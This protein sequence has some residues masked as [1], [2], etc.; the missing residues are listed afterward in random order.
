MNGMAGM[1]FADI[2]VA[3]GIF[4][5]SVTLLAVCWA[6]VR[7]RQLGAA[8]GGLAAVGAI[9]LIASILTTAEDPGVDQL[10]AQLAQL[11]DKHRQAGAEANALRE[12]ME[13]LRA[14]GSNIAELSAELSAQL[15]EM[16]ATHRRIATDLRQEISAGLE[17][18]RS[19]LEQL[20]M[21]TERCRKAGGC[22][23]PPNHK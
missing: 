8:G 15:D 1:V 11:E 17:D 12:D 21:E 19:D 22:P 20:R 4:L 5:G 13:N 14:L 9:L 6:Y 16:P 2:A 7:H 18:I 10:R 3:A 23:G